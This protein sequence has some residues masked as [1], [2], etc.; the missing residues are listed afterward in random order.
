MRTCVAAGA[1]TASGARPALVA[2]AIVLAA[3]LGGARA[4]DAACTIGTTPLSFGTYDV[5]ATSPDDST[6]TITFRCGNADVDVSI[7][8]GPGTANSYAPRKMSGAGGDKL[9]YNIYIDAN[10]TTVWGDGTGGSTMFTRHNP[11]NNRDINVSFY[12]RVPGGQD[13]AVGDYADT[14]VVTIN[15]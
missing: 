9:S 10:R 8:F 12:G 11:Q 14:V 5:F 2:A 13:V 1:R 6:G 15:F 7:T 3:S 4:A